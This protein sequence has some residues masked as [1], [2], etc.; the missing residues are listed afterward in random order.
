VEHDVLAATRK[1]DLQERRKK[2]KKVRRV[3]ARDEK[4]QRRGEKR[5]GPAACH[6]SPLLYQSAAFL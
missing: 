1:L 2:R 4:R 6:T 5:D 3:S